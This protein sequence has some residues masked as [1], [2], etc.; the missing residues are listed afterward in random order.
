[1]IVPLDSTLPYLVTLTLLLLSLSSFSSSIQVTSS[2]PCQSVCDTATVGTVGDD[3]VCLDREFTSTTNGS[4]FRTCVE[5][6]LGSTAVD[7]AIGDTDVTWGL[8]L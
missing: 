3:I 1:M 4:N 6:K 2:S 8:C 5:C 7:P